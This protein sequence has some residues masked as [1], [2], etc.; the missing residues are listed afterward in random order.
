MY[1]LQECTLVV[2]YACLIVPL[3]KM[4][5]GHK[6]H[7]ENGMLQITPRYCTISIFSCTLHKKDSI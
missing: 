1:K 7:F 6:T 2:L 4:K 3:S 5:K